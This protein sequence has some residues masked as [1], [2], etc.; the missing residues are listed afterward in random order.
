MLIKKLNRN[1]LLIF[2]LFVL[3]LFQSKVGLAEVLANKNACDPRLHGCRNYNY[4]H[5]PHGIPSDHTLA[6]CKLY[7]S[8]N[9]QGAFVNVEGEIQTYV[10]IIV[11]S[12]QK[13]D[14]FSR[15][16]NEYYAVYLN[17]KGSS[18]AIAEGYEFHLYEH[19]NFNGSSIIFRFGDNYVG[20]AWDKRGS[21]SKCIK[22]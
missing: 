10:G 1:W 9:R 13:R 15:L 3:E 17:D 18:V 22:L 20:E 5:N 2:M 6:K 14:F 11:G 21:S 7:T 4:I 12:E 16:L 19:D 8:E